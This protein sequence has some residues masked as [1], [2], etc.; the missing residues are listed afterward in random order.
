MKSALIQEA[1]ISGRDTVA[2][3][4]FSLVYTNIMKLVYEED[5]D[6]E[7][8]VY[9]EKTHDLNQRLGAVAKA[10]MQTVVYT[11]SPRSKKKQPKG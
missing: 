7:D 5:G 3:D 11:M 4:A 9:D 8:E 6:F 2:S 1:K 10:G